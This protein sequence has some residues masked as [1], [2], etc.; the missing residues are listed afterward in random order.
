MNEALLAKSIPDVSM[1]SPSAR[2][3][4][5]VGALAMAGGA[6]TIAAFDPS[7]NGFF[8]VCPL[9]ALTGFA[10]P[11]CGLTRSLHALLHGDIVPALD[12]NLLL[13]L[14]I[15]IFGAFFVSLVLIAARGRGT[16]VSL[17][18]PGVL[19]TFLVVLI[20]F[21]I[22]RNIPQWPFTILFP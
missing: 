17:A 22:V 21:G 3:L 13:P 4:A 8:P 7:K 16:G 19:T 12:F 10:C 11:G 2:V 14:W 5:S 6:V 15:L 18:G 9:L 20:T 1:A